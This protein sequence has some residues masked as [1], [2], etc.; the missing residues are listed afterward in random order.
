MRILILSAQSPY[1]AHAGGALRVLGLIKGLHQAGHT[2]DLLT[3]NGDGQP[4]PQQ[5]PLAALCN[6]IAVVPT[7]VRPL[8]V[9]LRELLTGQA[10]LAGRLA[11][12]TYRR[13]LIDL[14]QAARY[15]VVQA[16]GLEVAGYLKDARRTQP[17]TATI[18]D[19]FNVE[20]HLQYRMFQADRRT[21]RRLPIALYSL[22]QCRRLRKLEQRVCQAATAV[23]ATSDTDAGVL[24]AFTPDRRPFVVPNGI[25]VAEYAEPQNSSGSPLE[26]GSAALLFTGSMNYRPNVDAVLWF[27]E[28]VLK[29]IRQVVPEATLFVVGQQP[30]PRLNKLRQRPDIKITGYVQEVAPFLHGCT[31]YVAPLH[32]GSGTR[33]KLLQAMAA[34]CAIVSTPIGAEGLAIVNGRDGILID[35]AAEFAQAVIDLLRDPARRMAL[36]AAASTL[37]ACEYDWSVLM[38]RLL[39]IYATLPLKEVATK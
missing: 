27:A 14:L 38:P 29:H 12:E 37:V 30:H 28:H 33:L 17:T 36:G 10:D 5:S 31:V 16:E 34:H 26:L 39:S 22:I 20:Y 3:F 8:A 24:A 35:G 13:A 21:I 11:S 4:D 32:S 6:R 9:R 2:V 1:P 25:D 18:Y 19:A 15:E 7:P 23:I